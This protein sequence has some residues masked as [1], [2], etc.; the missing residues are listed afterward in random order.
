MFVHTHFAQTVFLSDSF[1][2]DN[3]ALS[4]SAKFSQGVASCQVTTNVRLD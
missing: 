4:A 1:L 2:K 3:A